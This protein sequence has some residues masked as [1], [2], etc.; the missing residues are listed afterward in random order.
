MSA[1]EAFG[2]VVA[3]LAGFIA[4][5]VW[6]TPFTF[7]PLWLRFAPEAIERAEHPSATRLGRYAVALLASFVQSFALAALFVFSG[8]SDLGFALGMAG[9]IWLGFIVSASLMDGLFRR[10]LARDWLLDM[11]HRLLV[12][13]TIAIV[14]GLWPPS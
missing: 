3:G 10:R 1:Y 14:L 12:L 5:A 6:Y 11:G 2:A 9:L 7:G 8:R 4:G 13:V